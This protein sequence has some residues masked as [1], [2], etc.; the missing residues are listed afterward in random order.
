MTNAEK[1]HA[2]SPRRDLLKS[3]PEDLSQALS[4]FYK[5]E[6]LS[7]R[8]LALFLTSL[9][10]HSF[11]ISFFVRFQITVIP[12]AFKG[13]RENAPSLPSPLTVSRP[14]PKYRRWPSRSRAS[15]PWIS[16]SR[17]AA[18]TAGCWRRTSWRPT[19]ASSR[20]R[21]GCFG[22]RSSSRRI[23]T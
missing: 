2:A 23:R 4:A 20:R 8:I 15:A 13:Y 7:T 22:P 9:C 1:V 19:P 6:R 21:C 18:A 14:L 16:P 17:P 10:V 11:Q 3:S 5:N 12:F